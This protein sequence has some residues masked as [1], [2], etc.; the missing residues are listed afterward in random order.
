MPPIRYAPHL[1]ESRDSTRS[2]RLNIKR[3]TMRSAACMLSAFVSVIVSHVDFSQAEER[4]YGIEKRVAWTTSRLVGTPEP[5]LPYLTERV[6]PELTFENPVDLIAVPG[7]DQMLLLELN[8]K[9]WTFEN[10]ADVTARHLAADLKTGIEDMSRLYGFAFHPDFAQNGTVYLCY[11]LQQTGDPQGTHLS[12]FKVSSTDPLQIDLSTEEIVLTWVNGG[13]NGGSLQF[14]PDDG[15]LYVSTGDAS[16]PF[17]PDVH[18]TGQD[19]SDLLASVL[20]IDVDHPE[21]G[22]LYSIPD[23]NPF[24]GHDNARGEVWCYGLRNPWRMSFDPVTGDLWVGDVGWELWEMVYRVE[25]GA[26]Y[27]WSILEHTQPV[28]PETPRGPTPIVPP[29]AAHSH[30]E[31][32]SMTGGYVYRGDRIDD[33]YGTSI[34]GDYVTGKIWGI[35][36]QKGGFSK[37]RELATAPFQVIC[38]GVDHNNELY[39]VGYDGTIHRVVPNP[40]AGK[41][42]SFPR[43]LSESG[44]FSSVKDYELAPGVIPYAIIAEPW[45]DGTTS[46]RF[47]ALPGDSQLDVHTGNNVQKG[48]LRGEWKYPD[49]TVLGKTIELPYAAGGKRRLETQI[50]HRYE[51]SWRAYSYIWN[52][53][54]TDATLLEG[55]GFDRAI[56]LRDPGP[57]GEPRQQTWHFASRTECILC[58]TTRGGSVYGF[59]PDQLHRDFDYGEVTDK[60]LRTFSHI[61]LLAQS[62]PDTEPLT[63]PRDE[64]EPLA[65]RVRSYLHVNCASCHRRGGGG[66]AAL[67]V[68]RNVSFSRTNLL[69]KPTQGTFGMVEPWLV[70]PG[71][72]YRSILYYRVAKLG[73]GR[74]PHFG[75]E[76]VDSHGMNMIHDWIAQ[77]E[78]PHDKADELAGSESA[79]ALKAANSKAIDQLTT[80]G[81]HEQAVDRLLASTG[82]AL[83]L[84]SVL[85]NNNPPLRVN[86]IQLAVKKGTTHPETVVRDLFESFL[87]EDERVKRLGTK[88][89]TLALLGM[90]GNAERG[91]VLFAKTQGLQCRNCHRVGDDGKAVGPD[92]SDVGKRYSR[93]EILENIL[94]PSKKIDAKFRTWLVQTSG[95]L[96]H[97]GLLVERTDKAVTL[98]DATGKTVVISS[99]DIELIVSQ[100]KSLMPELLLRDVTAQDAADLLAYLASLRGR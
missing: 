76:V 94:D 58:H 22:R 60:Q 4:P 82:G 31:S 78:T 46:S 44:L 95:G 38:F 83:R 87:P 40:D 86:A 25:R 21:N 88:I 96:V 77:L 71:D 49:G 39:V 10:S 57:K 9:V 1:I 28:N 67:E 34:Y 66:T 91:R 43:Q 20:R 16:P 56:P 52:D 61:G 37:P 62:A 54:Q 75:S 30:T 6:F 42:F 8:G 93:A 35:E 51:D 79:A 63:D 72:P 3:I 85:R 29:T 15:M 89:D 47:V 73:R 11:V 19:I 55:E 92:L 90:P 50:L 24:V 65:D 14:G 70:V 98:R 53:D 84:L 26:N 80:D 69:T 2:N 5:P 64:S 68:Q 33:L 17:P 36:S 23:D 18:K 100:Q 12:R 32:R 74:M 81:G 99:A 97:S 45:A 59:R 27:G 41:R 48:N 13:H 7:T